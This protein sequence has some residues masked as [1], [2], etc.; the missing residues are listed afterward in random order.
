MK[1][2]ITK[3]QNLFNGKK[4]YVMVLFVEYPDGQQ[5]VEFFGKMKEAQ[6]AHEEYIGLGATAC[7]N[8]QKTLEYR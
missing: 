5:K 6:R 8:V 1:K 4:S 2:M 3:L 7:L